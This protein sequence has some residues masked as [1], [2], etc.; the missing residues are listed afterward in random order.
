M[1]PPPELDPYDPAAVSARQRQIVNQLNAIRGLA[2]AI[3]LLFVVFGMG[4]IVIV[5]AINKNRAATEKL[6]DTQAVL[7][8]EV[9]AELD[10]PL[11]PDLKCP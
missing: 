4:G 2:V 7:I 9:Y 10:R 11:P 1:T 6:I 5:T 8:C 3:V